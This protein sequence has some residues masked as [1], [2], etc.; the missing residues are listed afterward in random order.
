MLKRFP[1]NPLI[2]PEAVKPSH[3]DLEVW[4]AFN[5][6]AA[7]YNGKTVLLMRVAERPRPEKGYVSTVFMDPDAP[8]QYKFLRVKETDPDLDLFD[9]RGVFRYKGQSY[10][11][12]IS[13]IR[14]A[15]SV[16][17]R[18][19]TVADKPAIMPDRDYETF[20]VED[21]RIVFLDGAYYINYTGVSPQGVVTC[22]A[23]TRD[24]VTYEKLGIV[25]APE[26]KDMAIFPEKLNGR[27]MCFHRPATKD[28][29]S[30]SIWF[31]T[32]SDL[33]AWGPH[34]YVMGPRPGMWDAERVGGG[35][36]PIKTPRGWLE[37][38]HGADHNIRYCSAA[39]LLDLEKPWKVIA[40]SRQPILAPEAAYEMTGFLP[41]VVF[42]N[43]LVDRGNGQLDIYYGGADTTVCGATL[44][45]NA[46]L[47]SLK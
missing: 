12:C 14:L 35:A 46:V 34:H 10:L 32:S 37:I 44:D 25:L 4:R 16:D 33:L 38:Y 17:G 19:F 30:P 43:G 6:G 41:N 24:F 8:G 9:P 45:V 15:T 7:T 21:P 26:N 28:V 36:S 23:R 39:V 42:H 18:K 2:T 3:P 11:Y 31:A 1:E 5:A 22:L 47:D 20:G 13:H 27:Y 29:G 40:R